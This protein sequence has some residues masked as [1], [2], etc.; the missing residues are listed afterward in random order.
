MTEWLLRSVHGAW[1][2]TVVLTSCTVRVT[3]I[4]QRGVPEGRIWFR[5]ASVDLGKRIHMVSTAEG[6]A[7]SSGRGHDVPGRAYRFRYGRWEPFASFPYSDSPHI[8]PRD[9]STIWV[10]HHLV[11]TDAYRPRLLTFRTGSFDEI[12]LPRIMWDAV[13][14]VIWNGIS[15][16]PNGTAWL[17]GQ[18][19]HILFYNGRRWNQVESPVMNLNRKTAYEGDLN[20]VFMLSPES[21]WAVGRDGV[22]LR[23]NNGRWQRFESPTRNTLYRVAMAD[24]TLGWCVGERGTILQFD[25]TR[26]YR[27]PTEL[28]TNL[29]SVKSLSRDKAWIVGDQST[30]LQYDGKSWVVDESIKIFDDAFQDIGVARDAQGNPHLWIIGNDGIYTTSQALGFSFTDITGQASLRRL[31]K[32]ALFLD[33]RRSGYP[34]LFIFNEEGPN[35]LYQNDGQLHFT[36]ITTRAGLGSGPRDAFVIAAGDIDNDGELDILQLVDQHAL[37]LYLGT[38]SGGFRDATQES[39]L[40]ALD[41]NSAAS[42]RF[43]DFDN[44]GNLD[45]YIALTDVNDIIARGDGAGRFTPVVSPLGVDEVADGKSRGPTFSDFNG[46]GLI[47]VF[48]PYYLSVRGTFFDLFLNR[49]GFVFEHLDQKVFHF[50]HDLSPYAAIAHDF[51]NDGR[52]DILVYCQKAPPLLLVNQGEALFEERSTEAGFTEMIFHPDP[53]NGVLNAADVNNDGWLDV[54]I[55]SRLFINSSSLRFS[56]SSDQTG[57]AFLGSPTFGDIDNDGDPDLFLGSSRLALGKGDRAAL[58]RNNAETNRWIKVRVFGDRS[59]RMALGAQVTVVP[60]TPTDST[61]QKREVGLGSSPLLVQDLSEVSFGLTTDAP[62]TVRVLFPSGQ[63][64]VIRGVAPRTILE[65]RESPVPA[66]VATLVSRSLDRTWRVIQWPIEL[67]KLLLALL[68]VWCSVVIARRLG[69]GWPWYVP[70]SLALL[71]LVLLHFTIREGQAISSSISFGTLLVTGSGA[72]VLGKI[73]A[74]KRAETHISHY[75]LIEQIGSGGMGSV[76]K[77]LDLTSKRVVA[78]KVLHPGLLSDP[79]NRR[80]LSSEGHLLSSFSHPHI[81]RVFEVANAQDRGYIA[82][83]YLPGGTLK[84]LL[85]R[86]HPLPITSI[87][88]FLLQIAGGLAEIH[89]HAIVHRD[90]KTGNIMLDAE[91]KIRIMDFGLSKSPLV[92]TMTSLGTVLGTLGYVAPEQIT[93]MNLDHRSDIFSFGVVAYELLTNILPFKGENEIA[94]IHSIFNTVPPPPSALRPDVSSRIDDIVLRCLAKDPAQR[95]QTA[96][97]IR[98][99]VEQDFS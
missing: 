47:D 18:Q 4:P 5:Q 95:F 86:E 20:D 98:L 22:I 26:W 41:L 46:D 93:N 30:L 25:G 69:I 58:L 23:Y 43:V 82:M 39:G 11:H 14:Y 12:P 48:I 40:R 31:G 29:R 36:D 50:D 13:D 65:V 15:V 71:Y 9:S 56:E 42:A 28:R 66:R 84:Q 62:H 83:E 38:W 87:R 77:A 73:I 3:E 64:R 34:D 61:V 91:G 85:E 55:S 27:I 6:F 10:L 24:E 92:T 94:L 53:I 96:A 54:F 35:L 97:E 32:G 33:R 88:Q 63:E 57:L 17:V 52:S 90:L 72:L 44:D 2:V 99:A 45:L 59:N 74:R 75:K 7:I 49:G 21:G 76:Y 89:Q 67:F 70:V 81:V 78:L 60:E 51:N 19:G 37:R 68:F 80:R 79:E 1:F 8:L 16:L